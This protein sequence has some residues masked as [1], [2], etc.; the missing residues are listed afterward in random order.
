[1]IADMQ[2]TRQL[3]W[4]LPELGWEVEVLCPSGEY[5]PATCFVGSHLAEELLQRGEE[6]YV[7][8]DLST[9]AL[10]ISST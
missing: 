2:R 7:L 8:D 5:Q 4:E 10:T 6:V 1:M 9:G 3:A